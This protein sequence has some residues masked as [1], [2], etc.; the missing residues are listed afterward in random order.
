VNYPD[1]LDVRALEESIREMGHSLRRLA[2]C[3]GLIAARLGDEIADTRVM[4]R[5][6]RLVA[7]RVQELSAN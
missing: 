5:P 4:E 6:E 2:L 7:Y 1:E 3:C